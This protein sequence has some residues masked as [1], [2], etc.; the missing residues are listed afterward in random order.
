MHSEPEPESEKI[1]SK[2]GLES[3]ILRNSAEFH[4]EFTNKARNYV[5]FRVRNCMIVILCTL[6][7]MG[8]CR[9]QCRN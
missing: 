3:E 1:E 8:P 7:Y 2:K 9:N 5:I 4:S 6:D